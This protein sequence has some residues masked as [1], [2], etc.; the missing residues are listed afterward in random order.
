M[1]SLLGFEHTFN[2][3]NGGEQRTIENAIAM[4]KHARIYS[5]AAS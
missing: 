1:C 5:F 4:F 2:C 3:N